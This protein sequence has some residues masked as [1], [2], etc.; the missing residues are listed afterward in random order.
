MALEAKYQIGQLVSH[1]RYGYRGAVAGFDDGCRASEEWYVSN[2]T[3]PR[4]DQTWYHV[5]VH[6]AEHTTYVAEENL[7]IDAGM[8]QVVHPLARVLFE[9]FANGSYVARP[10][11]AISDLLA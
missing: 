9:S 1:R 6:G 2:L 11:I 8:E 5:L 10:D 7:E 4:R 3:Q